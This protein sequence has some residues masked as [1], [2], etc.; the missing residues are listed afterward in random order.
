V[1]STGTL[2]RCTPS[3]SD[4][5]C[6]YCE[7]DGTFHALFGILTP[8]LVNGGSSVTTPISLANGG[9]GADVS[10]STGIP[11]VAGGTFSFVTAPS[12][13]LVGRTDT[14][15]LTNKT[16]DGANNTLTVRLGSDVTGTLGMTNGGFGANVSASSGLPSFSAGSITWKTTP[17]GDIV[18][19]SD[20]QALTNKTLTSPTLG[21]TPVYSAT[22]VQATGNT[23][24]K[25]YSDIASVQTTD[26]TVT[27]AFTWTIT[28]EAVTVVTVEACAVQ[29]TGSTTASYVRRVRIKRDG[30]TVTVGTVEST[31]T[32]EEAG[33][34][35][36]DI[37]IDNSGST[38]RVR[39]TGVLATTIDWGVVVTRLE[40]THA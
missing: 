1:S 11:K 4:D 24:A 13:D 16:I 33:F 10:A 9:F 19:T 23:R 28:D 34:A 21:G 22:S 12:G 2:E 14:Q 31:F 26:A 38:G 36:C 40:V 18:G 20:S 39:V 37:T 6:G 7:A 30:G 27:S 17:S 35:T 32:D 3:G 8:T 15:T 5:I 25:V 29:N